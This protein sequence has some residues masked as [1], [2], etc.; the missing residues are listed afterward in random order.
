LAELLLLCKDFIS[1]DVKD[2]KLRQNNL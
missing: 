1:T 2:S